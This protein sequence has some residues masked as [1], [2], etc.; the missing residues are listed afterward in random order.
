MVPFAGNGGGARTVR[1]ISIW[2]ATHVRYCDL[3]ATPFS[4]FS[5]QV[6]LR[7][8]ESQSVEA[9][10]AVVAAGAPLSHEPDFGAGF[11]SLIQRFA[12]SHACVCFVR[13]PSLSM[14]VFANI[15][16]IRR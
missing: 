9:V 10:E 13:L 4:D 7:A 5:F 14:R 12:L 11:G 15:G 3:N 2:P 6:L 16:Y 8:I 1:G